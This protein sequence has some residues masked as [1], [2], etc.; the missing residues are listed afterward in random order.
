MLTKY[1]SILNKKGFAHLATIMSD[2]TPQTTPVW[3]DTENDFIRVNTAI[4]RLKDRNMKSRSHVA[5]SILDPE[6]PY[7]YVTIRGM[8]EERTTEGA[9]DHIDLLAKKYLGMDKY[10][11][12]S[13]KEVRVIYR[14]KPLRVFGME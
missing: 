8:V 1:E 9:D 6:N 2:G 7:S 12:R 14:I 13:D 11:Y 5:L 10:P 3:F 4:D